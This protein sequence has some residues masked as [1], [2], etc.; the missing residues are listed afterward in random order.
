MT[1]KT[2]PKNA[3]SLLDRVCVNR[4][5]LD[6]SKEVLSVSVGQR[7]A[8]AQAFKVGD[9]QKSCRSARVEPTAGCLGSSPGRWDHAQSLTDHTFASLLLTEK[10]ST[11]FERSEP[12]L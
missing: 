1:S 8:K 12:L 6:L 9:L 3:A 5:G 11:S 7:T 10:H 4:R 2:Y